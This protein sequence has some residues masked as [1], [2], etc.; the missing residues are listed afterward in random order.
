MSAPYIALDI[1]LKRIGVAYSPDGLL[2]LP[3]TPILRKNRNQASQDVLKVL[4]EYKAQTVVV[5][6]PLGGADEDVMRQ[7]IE[8]FMAL[9]NYPL[10]YVFQDEWGS[11]Q[12]ANERL[13]GYVKNEK[14]GK[15]D[16]IAA[17][18]ILERWLFRSQGK[19]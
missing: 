5:G 6:I 10:S 15:S 14:N 7:R 4:T 16:S 12:E 13:R 11:S 2:A 19:F 9:V 18:I 1:G 17:V 3:L 8:H